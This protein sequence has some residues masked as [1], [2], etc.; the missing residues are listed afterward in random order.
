[1][2]IDVQGMEVDV[3]KGACGVFDSS[4]VGIRTE[5]SFFELYKDQPLFAEIDTYL[6]TRGFVAMRFI[7]MHDWRRLTSSKREDA[8]NC[9]IAHSNGQLMHGDVLY[10]RH[11]EDLE[12]ATE[13]GIIRLIRLALVAACYGHF[14]HAHAIFSRAKIKD[15]CQESGFDALASLL[16]TAAHESRWS[17]RLLRS[18]KRMV[19][20]I[21]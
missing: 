14:D 3:F 11:P 18:M 9:E 2:K 16:K 6:R 4:L 1:M 10:L 12:T 7:E 15:Y 8:K 21:G 17:Q 20:K 19:N 5:V 13:G